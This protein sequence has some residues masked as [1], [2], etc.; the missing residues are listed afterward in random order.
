[1]LDLRKTN[2][3]SV[4]FHLYMTCSYYSV[5]FLFFFFFTVSVLVP[6]N[7]VAFPL[8]DLCVPP[9]LASV[10]CSEAASFINAAP[11]QLQAQAL[12]SWPE[13]RPQLTLSL[14]VCISPSLFSS[15]SPFVSPLPS[16][17]LTFRNF[18]SPFSR[19]CWHIL[20]K[21]G[22]FN[23]VVGVQTV[24]TPFGRGKKKKKA[25]QL[26]ASWVE[27]CSV[28]T[29]CLSCEIIHMMLFL[30]T[31]VSLSLGLIWHWDHWM[32]SSFRGNSC[33][34]WLYNWVVQLMLFVVICFYPPCITRA[35][36]FRIEGH[37]GN[38]LSNFC[39]IM[40]QK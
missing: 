27:T 17:Q 28:N 19:Q 2:I 5:F 23:P 30:F 26:V 22:L 40:L 3:E 25:G 7:D 9:S 38:R 24:S 32:K 39:S 8:R 35:H 1:M 36:T 21:P 20:S 34:K 33:L 4:F 15:S 29:F 6:E 31:P 16:P 37:G 13:F 14:F 11:T 18:P 10:A 12:N